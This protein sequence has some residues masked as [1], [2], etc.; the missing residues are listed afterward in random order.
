MYTLASRYN[1]PSNIRNESLGLWYDAKTKISA[2]MG[3][4]KF[5]IQNK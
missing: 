1:L 4:I 2:C 3:D 5:Q